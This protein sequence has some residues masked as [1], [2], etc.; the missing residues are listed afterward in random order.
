M[1][2]VLRLGQGGLIQS[3]PRWGSHV[4]ALLA[5]WL[6]ALSSSAAEPADTRAAFLKLLDRPRVELAPEVKP[7]AGTNGL[8]TV[9]FSFAAEAGVRVPGLLIH[10]GEAQ[11]RRP[12][13]IVLHGTGANK[14]SQLSL[15]TDLAKRGFLAVAIDG[16]HHGARTKAG[17][18][19]AEYHEAILNAWFGSKKLPFLYDTAWDVMRL[20]DY[21]GTR[22]DVDAA[23]IGLI[24]FSKGGM[25]GYLAAAA[26]PRIA[27]VVPC[28]GVQS[29]KWA[30][31]NESWRS[32]VE[33]FKPA[34]DAAA[35]DEGETVSAAFVRRFYDRVVPGIYGQFDGPAML[36]LIAPRPLLVING[37]ADMRTPLPGVN[38]CLTAARTAY[39]AA[40]AEPKLQVILQPQTGHKVTVE[41]RQAAVDWFVKWLRP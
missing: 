5:L 34:L 17:R 19:S 7:P 40:G 1:S 21:L 20:V 4:A 35:K 29:F 41:A 36:P 37:E 23:R 31:D 38:E 15:L 18:G 2:A 3:A 30:L 6:G 13:V 27:V 12:V 9:H 39:R 25:E 11:G 33:T 32:R 8:R 26:D 22:D 14:E 24:G 16:R 28:I 10:R